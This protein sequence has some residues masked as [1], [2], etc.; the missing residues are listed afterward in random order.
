MVSRQGGRAVSDEEY[1]EEIRERW[2]DFLHSQILTRLSI[3]LS[4]IVLFVSLFFPEE[5]DDDG[6]S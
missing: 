2:E 3:V 5:D 1:P 4:I 6:R